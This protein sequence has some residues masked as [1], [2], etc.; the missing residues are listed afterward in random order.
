[1]FSISISRN[2]FF[3]IKTFYRHEFFDFYDEDQ[4]L[5][6]R[7]NPQ[8]RWVL[9]P[10]PP[11]KMLEASPPRMSPWGP[12]IL[13]RIRF[14]AMF[15]IKPLNSLG[16]TSTWIKLNW[17]WIRIGLFSSLQIL[18]VRWIIV[19]KC[20]FEKIINLLYIFLRWLQQ[21]DKIGLQESR[22]YYQKS[23]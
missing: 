8:Y 14:P 15:P 7:N 2:H 19:L 13:L 4:L 10:P 11:P 20:Y 23:E 21:W 22:N 18:I 17:T 5:T 12:P 1:M 6:H 3:K 9:P 16:F